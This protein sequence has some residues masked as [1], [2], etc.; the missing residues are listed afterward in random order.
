M[1][2]DAIGIDLVKRTVIGKG[3]QKLRAQNQ[4]PAVIHDHGGQSIHV[5]GDYIKLTK[6]FAAAGRHHPVELTVDGKKHLALI[7]QVDF[8]PTKDLLRHIVFQ[9]IEQNVKV[10]AEIPVIFKEGV[11][12]PAEKMS[13]L[14]LKQLD[15]VEVKALPK[16]LPDE[17]VVDPSTLKEVGDHLTVADIKLPPGVELV[18][19]PHAQIA[20]VEEPK[21][22]I[23]EADA[24]AEALAEESAEEG[25][26]VESEHGQETTEEDEGA[27]DESGDKKPAEPKDE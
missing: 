5:M 7:K 21:D 10:E 16:D 15:Y 1:S 8:E 2:S 26:D 17:L 23:A 12:I 19:D 20:Y 4:V 11:D 3:L 6:A 18:G 24:A 22:Q 27:E 9:A 14:V 13:L 25:V